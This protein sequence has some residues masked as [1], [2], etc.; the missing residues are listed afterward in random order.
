MKDRSVQ[1]LCTGDLHLGRHPTRIPDRID[2]PAFSLRSV[3]QDIV[4]A[5]I[6]RQ[7]DGVVLTGGYRGSGKPHFEAYGAFEAGVIDLDQEDIPVI[8]VAGNHDSEF[9]PRM[10]DVIGLDNLHLLGDGGS[11]ERW[12]L[13]LNGHSAVHLDGWSVDRPNV[14]TSPVDD[15]DLPP[16]AD[17]P[18]IGIVHADLDSPPKSICRSLPSV[19]SLIAPR[20][21]TSRESRMNKPPP[22]P[23]TC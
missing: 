4:R 17:G 12:T 7:V 14:S 6:R 22:E 11:W 10:V 13:E 5:A 15:Y 18:Q 23:P 2:G 3:W 1:L 19:M 8:T 9:L 20:M 16:A 21:V